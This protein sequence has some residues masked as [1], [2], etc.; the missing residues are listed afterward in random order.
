M[1]WFQERLYEDFSQTL[2]VERMIY[3]GRTAFQSVTIFENRVFGKVLALD[4]IVQLTDRDSHIYHEMIAHAPAFA[5]GSPAHALIV[6]GG[7]GGVLK[8]I[9][10]HPSVERATLVELDPEVIALSREHF[11]AVSDGAFDDPRAEIVIGD[12]AAFVAETDRTF[13][14]IIVDSTDPIGPGEAL[15]ADAFY[16]NCRKRLRPGGII[17][18]QGGAAFFQPEKVRA[19]RDR[20]IRHFGAAQC[21]L[22]PVPTYAA[23]MLALI[24]GGASAS[25]LL[26]DPGVLN[27]RY[28][29]LSAKPRFYAPSVHHAAFSLASAI[30]K[31]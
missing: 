26:P 2:S 3:R 14:L 23:G 4:D 25:A 27:E 29:T 7:D 10:L 31:E 12:G 18:I 24:S 17:T 5:H 30:E 1:T 20:L 19:A 16:E 22:A 13:D 15:Y 11:P 8:E 28:R 21:Y 6:G 9:L